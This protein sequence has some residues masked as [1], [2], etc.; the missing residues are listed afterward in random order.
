MAREGGASRLTGWWNSHTDVTGFRRLSSSMRSGSTCGSRS[1]TEMS[2]ICPS[3]AERTLLTEAQPLAPIW[4]G[5]IAVNHPNITRGR[6]SSANVTGTVYRQ[7]QS[8]SSSKCS[9]PMAKAMRMWAATH[10]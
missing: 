6:R 1:A 3:Y 2:R 4:R 7:H 8:D 9:Q 5:S 10:R